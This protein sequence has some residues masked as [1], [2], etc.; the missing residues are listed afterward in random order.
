MFPWCTK[1]RFSQV[2]QRF[3]SI[4]LLTILLPLAASATNALHFDGLGKDGTSGDYIQTEMTDATLGSTFTLEAWINPSQ[5]VDNALV[6][7]LSGN[8]ETGMEFHLGENG[9]LVFTARS[10]ANKWVDFKSAQ[11]LVPLNQ[12]S[13]VA[14]SFDGSVASF[15]VNGQSYASVEMLLDGVSSSSGFPG[16]YVAGTQKMRIGQRAS[17][18]NLNDGHNTYLG[19]MSEVQVW[20]VVRSQSEIQADA[21][22][23]SSSQTS[24][25]AYYPLD[26][27]VANGDNA[28]VT[29]ATDRVG[30]SHGVLTNFVLTGS[31][32]NWVDR[33]DMSIPPAGAGTSAADPYLIQSL[34]DLQWISNHP[35]SWS[36]YF[37][38][39][40]DID[41]S[42]T[43]TWNNGKGFS[44]IGNSASAFTGH[45]DGNSHTIQNLFM[46]WNN[47]DNVGLFGKTKAGS[48]ISFLGLVNASIARNGDGNG[49]G[50]LINIGAIV[51]DNFGDILNCF[52]ISTIGGINS[53][54]MGNFGGIAGNHTTGTIRNSYARVV[55][56]SDATGD[57]G[58]LVGFN[59]GV[60]QNSYAISNGSQGSI[61]VGALAGAFFGNSVEN[62]YASFN[63]G[64]KSLCGS[65]CD[66]ID[67]P[68][69]TEEEM[70]NRSLYAPQSSW[71][72][73]E[74]TTSASD[75]VWDIDASFNNGFPFL[76]WQKIRLSVDQDP[77]VTMEYDGTR[78]ASMSQIT[79]GNLVGAGTDDVTLQA[80]ARFTSKNIGTQLEDTVYY[81]LTGKDASK[82]VPPFPSIVQTGTITAKALQLPSITANDKAYDNSMQGSVTLV[83][84]SLVGVA[85]GDDVHL[86]IDSITFAQ[87]AQ[88]NDI[89][90]TVKLS[91]TGSDVPNY[92]PIAPTLQ[93][94]ADIGAPAYGMPSGSGTDGDEYLIDS[95]P[96][97]QWVS[98]NS[99][100]WG[101]YFKQ[102]KHIDASATA[103]WNNGEGFSPI[104]NA[105]VPFTGSYRGESHYISGLTIKANR[106]AKVGFFGYTKKAKIFSLGLWNAQ[107]EGNDTLGALVGHLDGGSVNYC[108][109]TG[110]VKGRKAVG[111][112]VGFATGNATIQ[113]CYSTSTVTAES[114]LGGLMGAVQSS[115]VT[116]CY[117]AGLV[118]GSTNAG[119]F[120][121]TSNDITAFRN[122]WDRESAGIGAM[123]DGAT[124]LSTAE[125]KQAES[126]SGWISD[127]SPRGWMIYPGRTYPLL[128]EYMKN[129]IMT[130]W[131]VSKEYDGV[132]FQ[133]GEVHY[134]QN[135]ESTS[136]IE[137]SMVG[138]AQGAIEY[139]TYELI[140]DF[141]SSQIGYNIWNQSGILT[142]FQKP[143]GTG[144][145]EDP[146]QIGNE[147][148]LVWM[149]VTPE[150][151]NQHFRQVNDIELQSTWKQKIG[152]SISKFSGS[153][154]GGGHRISG[155][156]YSMP[157]IQV[158]VFDSLAQGSLVDSLTI[159]LDSAAGY[160]VAGLAVQNS[161]TIRH[162]I[163]RDGRLSPRNPTPNI[164]AVDLYGAGLV[165]WNAGQ[166]ERSGAMLSFQSA[167]MNNLAG[168][169][170]ENRGTI[171]SCFANVN[172]DGG[173]YM[174]GLVAQN[175]GTIRHSNSSG[176]IQST[177]VGGG[178][179]GV[180]S[181]T[182][183]QSFA[184]VEVSALHGAGGVVG[185]NEATGIISESFADGDV[186]GDTQIGGFAG[187]NY[188]KIHT[189][190]AKG[191]VNSTVTD[192]G[193]FVG[194]NDGE[195][196]FSYA[197]GAVSGPSSVGGFAGTHSSG[198][199][200]A[201]SFWDMDAS[202]L[203]TGVSTSENTFTAVGLTTSEMM[204][205][206]KV[207][208]LGDFQTTWRIYE[209]S[210]YPLLRKYLMPLTITVAP[211]Q[212]VYDGKP[213]EGVPTLQMPEDVIESLV[214]SKEALGFHPE[215]SGNV[216]FYTL[217][218][219]NA[220]YSNQW[221]YDIEFD[222]T[223][224]LTITRAPL[225]ITAP[226]LTLNLG[227]APPS[228]YNFTY[229][230][231]VNGEDASVL[232]GLGASLSCGE[233]QTA[234]VFD[235]VPSA[236]A[237]NYAI[238]LVN[239]TLTLDA[240]PVRIVTR[241]ATVPNLRNLRNYD[242][243]GRR[244]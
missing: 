242:L 240:I 198:G 164:F 152:N 158:G 218:V 192:V 134:S 62:S 228:T 103:T 5:Q 16:T 239:G 213:F 29:Q 174:G 220:L 185:N 42:A 9:G 108:F 84:D 48:S 132:A 91:L 208:A 196:Q 12:W 244:R 150:S 97:L 229:S 110:T 79:L 123:Q 21:N 129:I 10:S 20:N 112:L 86:S 186:N 67:N 80:T 37:R 227:D 99:G 168:I 161:G 34:T 146:Y 18:K 156:K 68:I 230:G 163:V 47:L 147:G 7:T 27:G 89:A 184:E 188:G 50:N 25:L 133:G 235:I 26:Q 173:N 23:Y 92:L 177:T 215:A 193:G 145:E 139:G 111:G 210:T 66:G 138:S 182:I 76:K 31:A 69:Y 226:S 197:I 100:S 176:R 204:T 61:R 41:A 102:S 155:V 52:A 95:L 115:T 105:Q 143:A 231:F 181:G 187:N 148:N 237:T 85:A 194:R 45:Y 205:L 200:V 43:A 170:M 203:T 153:Y 90:V 28:S 118:S 142:I 94:T 121:G 39:T 51:G 8:T 216:G 189:S 114:D 166:I 15:F 191:A 201:N 171:D 149:T 222:N 125:M 46:S 165:L 64:Q 40:K 107:V 180:N 126:F 238:T 65:Y 101:A 154:H 78:N 119:G 195:I 124:P 60:I 209:G 104:G 22:G 35:S 212:K 96:N 169:A 160:M 11:N 190:Y 87:K 63:D 81:S 82:Y 70:R 44:P 136:L 221:G 117:S 24:Q 167:Y 140:S 214:M 157:W 13:H 178:L 243:L 72:F 113:S 59:M 77:V 223:A 120:I 137:G 58:G 162:V 183:E 175:F 144:S 202:G 128:R 233:C 38:Q 74:V 207:N 32:S 14:V 130:A 17:G 30:N 98:Q 33:G 172:L 179:V 232:T 224:S 234:G 4:A 199:L 36:S 6:S 56:S 93:L 55:L 53:D 127:I 71:A 141:Y 83:G 49:N 106:S 131:S 159:L 135:P 2:R 217:T 54:F 151:L 73:V 206:E 57:F 116:D 19:K 236:S 225:S 3:A 88:G 1:A 241:P 109:S 75:A 219:P 211:V 122:Y